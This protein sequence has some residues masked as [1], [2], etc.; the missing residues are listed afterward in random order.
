M[1]T[2]SCSLPPPRSL[3][4]SASPSR[5]ELARTAEEI[6]QL[7][8]VSAD[9]FGLPLCGVH[10]D[11]TYE[12]GGTVDALRLKDSFSKIA[13][14]GDEV[15]LFFYSDLFIKHPEIRDL[16]PISLKA[17]REHLIGALG[18]IV[19]RVDRVDDLGAFLEG[20]GR[21]HRKFG[22]LADHYDAVGDSL[23]ATLAHFAGDAWTPELAADWADAYRLI[24]AAMMAAAEA[25]EA[26]RPAFW[27]ASVI[28][29]ERKA[30]DI[31]VLQ[32]RPEP[33]LDFLPGQSVAIES[34][35]RPRLWRYYSIANAPRRDGTLDFHVRLIDGGAVSIAL[36][37]GLVVGDSLR[38][39]PPVGVLTLDTSSR[40]DV[41]LVA[42]S[43]GLAPLKAITEQVS[44][45]AQPPHV[46]L[47]FCAKAAEGLYDLPSLEKLAAE[48]HWLTVVPTVTADS[49][50]NG[51]KGTVPDVVMRAGNWSAH[52][53][54]L[55]GPTE[56]VREM[57]ARL[58]AGGTPR[59]RI[60]VEDF[61]WSE[62]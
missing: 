42:G 1:R 37:Y 10:R 45:Q 38:V 47:F 4:A 44:G 40:R 19:A 23:L 21:D 54:Y 9:G 22:A 32:V 8:D 33:R 46:H 28:S 34:A 27:R 59:E 49:R 26:T 15:P 24:A 13:M 7:T 2:P 60:H 35:H 5:P 52:D 14:H 6:G 25:D 18:Q 31:S 36:T 62:P 43:T 17:Q 20:L 29:C 50:F 53:A 3:P 39:G 30:F 48:Y 51:E 56:M 55:A 57:S 16:F 58:A 61:G 11:S 12:E 41:L